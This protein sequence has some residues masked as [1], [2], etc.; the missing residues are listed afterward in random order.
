MRQWRYLGWL[1]AGVLAACGDSD[2]GGGDLCP[3]LVACGGDVVGAWRVEDTC[4]N[5]DEVS[6]VFEESLPPECA[7][8]LTAAE[9]DNVDLLITYTAEGTWTTAGSVQ[10]HLE[11]TLTATC[12]TAINPNFPA[13]S[14]ASCELLGQ[15]T[16]DALAMV[17]AAGVASCT[18]GSGACECTNTFTV[19]AADTGEYT[20]DNGQI[21]IE[22][23]LM[24]YCVS[25]DSMRFGDAAQGVSTARRQ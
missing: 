16:Q 17:D 18:L 22:G 12:L 4:V 19:Q 1:A 11:Y 23:A 20:L 8:S 9:D 25:G 5:Q 7:G 10:N 6:R 24:P 21:V 3:P 15:G 2:E 13:L 14:S